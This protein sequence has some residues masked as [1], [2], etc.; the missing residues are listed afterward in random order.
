MLVSE[1]PLLQELLNKYK[2]EYEITDLTESFLSNFKLK[3]LW[4]N[5]VTSTTPIGYVD[6]NSQFYNHEKNNFNKN[7]IPIIHHSY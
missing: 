6:K 5:F 7:N 3:Y 4:D 1:L 2:I